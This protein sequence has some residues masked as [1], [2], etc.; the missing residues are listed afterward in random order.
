M[1][2]CLPAAHRWSVVCLTAW[3]LMV[4]PGCGTRSGAG[5]LVP[6][7]G[8][9]SFEGDALTTGSLSFRP[10]GNKGNT[11]KVEPFGTIGPDGTYKL[12][13]AQKEGAP[14]G[15]YKVIVVV[16]TPSNPKDPYSMPRSVIHKKY[17]D[18][19][20]TDLSVEVVENAAPGT[21]DLTVTK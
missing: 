9:V 10:D 4:L 3:F 19:K 13:T 2:F 5:K 20:T 6:V 8:K 16:D 15:W 1:C 11:S 7:I 12:F 17:R 14:T 21:Y 18:P